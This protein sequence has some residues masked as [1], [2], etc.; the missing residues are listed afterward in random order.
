MTVSSVHNAAVVTTDVPWLTQA[1]ANFLR[2][3]RATRERT[4]RARHTVASNTRRVWGKVP[5]AAKAAGLFTVLANNGAYRWTMEKAFDG[6]RK[7]DTL[8]RVATSKIGHGLGWVMDKAGDLA[9]YA[10]PKAARPFHWFATKIRG[11]FD[12]VASAGERR[13]EAGISYLEDNMLADKAVALVNTVATPIAFAST[14]EYATGGALT[15]IASRVA[16]GRRVIAAFTTLNVGIFVGALLLTS[17]FVGRRWNKSVA[18]LAAPGP[19]L[20]EVPATDVVDE[21]PTEHDVKVVVSDV[22][23]GKAEI[24][25]ESDVELSDETVKEI[26]DAAV[27]AHTA[28]LEAEVAAAEKELLVGAGARRTPPAKKAA[29]K[30]RR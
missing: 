11:A 10:H 13:V 2:A 28:D 21:Q 23:A 4:D 14:V 27:A 22:A 25:I 5:G 20:I 24:K 8:S 26:T 6:L 12:W 18:K 19:V 30:R 29:S 9:G 3:L 17:L 1:K 15:R 16:T 7:V